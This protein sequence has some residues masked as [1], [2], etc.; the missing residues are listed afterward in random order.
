VLQGAPAQQYDHFLYKSLTQGWRGHNGR[1][2]GMT[3]HRK[4]GPE[5]QISQKIT[6]GTKTDFLT[7]VNDGNEGYDALGFLKARVR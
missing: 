6:K 4:Y 5:D 1:S 7:G 2:V 3:T